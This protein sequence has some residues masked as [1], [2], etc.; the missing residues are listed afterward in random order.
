DID[1]CRYLVNKAIEHYREYYRAKSVAAENDLLVFFL[2]PCATKL[3]RSL[4]WIGGFRP[5]T[6]FH[7]AYTKIGMMFESGV[8][9]ILRGIRTGDFGDISPPQLQKIS[10]LQ[11]ETV[12]E[13]NRLKEL[14]KILGKADLLRLKTIESLVQLLTP[15]Q[16]AEF[17]IAAA[18][19]Q[20]GIRIWGVGHD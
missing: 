2:A 17:L 10:E 6:A 13:E 12:D 7:L 9:H 15:Q 20:F 11:I 8:M 14:S 18:E 1:K 16:S 19:L 4:S 3:E 5:T